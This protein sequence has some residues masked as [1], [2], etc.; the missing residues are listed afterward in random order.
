MSV[1][2]LLLVEPDLSMAHYSCEDLQRR[3]L[4]F[5]VVVAEI[6]NARECLRVELVVAVND[7]FVLVCER[8]C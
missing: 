3:D 1:E 5:F 4:T 6:T 7:P 8:H 2:V